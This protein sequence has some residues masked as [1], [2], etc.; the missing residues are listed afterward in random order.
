MSAWRER[1]RRLIAELTADLPATATIEQRRKLLWGR[2]WE[3]HQGT[4]WG[5]RMWGQEVRKHLAAH[6]DTMGAARAAGFQ[7]PADVHFPFR[8]DPATDADGGS[9]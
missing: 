6:G 5:R 3:A 9:E 7:W 2:G 4:V 8:N 1:A